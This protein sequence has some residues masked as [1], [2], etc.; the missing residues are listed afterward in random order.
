[1]PRILFTFDPKLPRDWAHLA[2]RKG[3]EIEL[4]VDQCERWIRRGVAVY[5]AAPETVLVPASAMEPAAPVSVE[6]EPTPE[7][8]A[9][10]QKK[11]EQKKVWRRK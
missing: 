7:P 2:Y 11:A 8:T 6:W 3:T 1:M 10:E 9:F 5:A 4:S